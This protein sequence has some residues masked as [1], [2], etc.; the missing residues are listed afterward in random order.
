MKPRFN[1]HTNSVFLHSRKRHSRK[2]P[3]TLSGITTYTFSLFLSSRKRTPERKSTTSVQ[4]L[5][6]INQ[7]F[8]IA[9]R[10]NDFTVLQCHISMFARYLYQYLLLAGQAPVSGHQ[11]P[12]L[13]WPLTRTIL[14][15]GQL[16]FPADFLIASRGCPLTRASTVVIN[17]Y[18]RDKSAK[19]RWSTRCCLVVLLVQDAPDHAVLG[20]FNAHLDQYFSENDVK[21]R[22]RF[23]RDCINYLADLLSDDLARNTAFRYA[24]PSPWA[25]TIRPKILGRISINFHG[26]MAQSFSS[27]EDDNCS[28]GIFQ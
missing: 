12:Q 9:V 28:F 20:F 24:L 6:F 23:G 25:L 21:S 19:T 22:F 16:Q 1:S 15:S 11:S 13:Q 2:R 27:V 8:C 10:H 14:V 18:S 17:H 4:Y 5:V 3:R 26:Q 7:P